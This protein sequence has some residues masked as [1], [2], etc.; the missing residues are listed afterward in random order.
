MGFI[1]FTVHLKTAVAVRVAAT[2]TVAVVPAVT[3]ISL[4]G[5]GM[6]TSVNGTSTCLVSCGNL[7]GGGFG[8]GFSSD[9]LDPLTPGGG[10]RSLGGTTSGL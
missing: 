4:E 8:L 9:V 2:D 5:R 7:T 1:A 3:S 6:V 10:R